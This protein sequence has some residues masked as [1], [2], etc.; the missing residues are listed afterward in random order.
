MSDI[1]TKNRIAG[2]FGEWTDVKDALPIYEYGNND[3]L[4]IRVWYKKRR[5]SDI[6]ENFEEMFHAVTKDAFIEG[7]GWAHDDD[8]HEV[9][10]W[11][12]MP[13]AEWFYN[14]KKQD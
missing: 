3:F 9:V 14:A 5:T 4:V 7:I 10:A 11:M 13:K 1:I 2:R 6:R 8:A 12:P